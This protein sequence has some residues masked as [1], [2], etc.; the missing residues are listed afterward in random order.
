MGY[1]IEYLL[2][3][4]EAL[5]TSYLRNEFVSL[6]VDFIATVV[7]DLEVSLECVVLLQKALQM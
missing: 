5:I 3:G 4:S 6:L 1:S 2:T 7:M